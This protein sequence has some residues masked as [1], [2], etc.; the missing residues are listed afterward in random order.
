MSLSEIFFL[1]DLHWFRSNPFSLFGWEVLFVSFILFYF[2]LFYF[3][4]CSFILLNSCF[5]IRLQNFWPSRE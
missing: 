2:I 1:R 3:I 5:I 4:L